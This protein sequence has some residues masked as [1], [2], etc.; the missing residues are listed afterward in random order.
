MYFDEPAPAFDPIGNAVRAMVTVTGFFVVLFVF[1][2]GPIVDAA[3]VAA[4]SLF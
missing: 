3:G 1:F 4:K 2:A